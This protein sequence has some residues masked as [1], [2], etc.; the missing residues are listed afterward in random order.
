MI[1]I[2]DWLVGKHLLEVVCSIFDLWAISC[3]AACP[4][5]PSWKNVRLCM[6]AL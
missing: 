6:Y 1:I 4:A 3:F 5:L 2:F